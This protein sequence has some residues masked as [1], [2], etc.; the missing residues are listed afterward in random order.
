MSSWYQVTNKK[1]TSIGNEQLTSVGQW[2]AD[3]SEELLHGG[4]PSR[5]DLTEYS[6][7]K[8]FIIKTCTDRRTDMCNPTDAIAS[9]KF[10][11]KEMAWTLNRRLLLYLNFTWHSPDLHLTIL[12]PSSELPLTFPWTSPELPL[13]FPWPFPDLSLNFP[14]PFPDRHLVLINVRLGQVGLHLTFTWPSPD[15]LLISSPSFNR[16]LS[17]V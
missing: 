17:L 12:L 11:I 7:V 16:P 6:S 8:N 5:V 4:I 15:L 3:T 14:W 1:L 2:A 10:V 9:N 13:T